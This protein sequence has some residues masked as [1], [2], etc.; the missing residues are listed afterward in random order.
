MSSIETQELSGTLNNTNSL[1]GTLNGDNNL[2]GTL[3]NARNSSSSGGGNSVLIIEIPSTLV[4]TLYDNSQ[5]EMNFASTGDRKKLFDNIVEVISNDKILDK[6][7]KLKYDYDG[8]KISVSLNY[9]EQGGVV[10]LTSI[11]DI[12]KDGSDL[13]VKTYKVG[14]QDGRSAYIR[15]KFE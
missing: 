10:V 6:I 2:Q 3:S 15:Y 9:N 13:L 5:I 14:L 11:A 12:Y 8:E 7:I 1:R 4:D